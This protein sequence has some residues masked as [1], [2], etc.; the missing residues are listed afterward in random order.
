VSGYTG[1]QHKRL[2]MTLVQQ[3]GYVDC[4]ADVIKFCD[5]LF[6]SLNSKFRAMKPLNRPLRANS[7]HVAFGA[8]AK[9]KLARLKFYKNGV[10][11]SL[12]PSVR[13]FI[14]TISNIEKL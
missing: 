5:A 4:T 13:H 12:P 9:Q 2:R 1:L 11:V 8:D 14:V 7:A 10:Q 3:F 6:D